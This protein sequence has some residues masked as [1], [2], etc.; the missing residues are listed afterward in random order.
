MRGIGSVVKPKLVDVQIHRDFKR[1]G[2]QVGPLHDIAHTQPEARSKHGSRMQAASVD[3]LLLRLACLAH[4]QEWT[5]GRALRRQRTGKAAAV[6]SVLSTLKGLR[7]VFAQELCSGPS[8]LAV[9][10]PTQKH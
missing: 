2:S 1:H 6:R 5:A 10:I 9:S 7:A 4:L 3:L 8:H